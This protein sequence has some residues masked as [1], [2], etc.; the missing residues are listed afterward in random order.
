MGQDPTTKIHSLGNW[1][2][3][4]R[5]TIRNHFV[6]M[7]GEFLGTFLFL[8]FSFAPTQ[9]AVTALKNGPSTSP[10]IPDTSALLF[11]AAAFGV[12]VT[13]NVWAF[14]R[15]NGGMLNPAVTLGL[16]LIGA[17]PLIRG[18]LVFPCQI[19][20]GISAAGVV[21]ALFPG[22]LLVNVSLGAGTSIVQ[23]LFIEMFLTIQFLVVIFMLAVEKHRAT[24]LAP[25][26]IGMTLFICHMTAVYYTGCGV[27]PARAFG[28]D[29]VNGGFPSYHWIYWLGPFM[30]AFVAAGIY[31]LFKILGYETANPGQDGGK[32]IV[33][34][35]YSDEESALAASGGV[36]LRC[37]Q[38]MFIDE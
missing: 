2:T 13:V 4:S 14:Y 28:P 5:N 24:F 37:F 32:E 11:I 21:S 16:V 29:V 17:V 9:I 12:S 19:L 33:G 22:P 27:N 34:L 35:L 7:I 36:E 20:A 6:A 25:I 1:T 15:I 38:G 8:F 30:G 31:K 26:G 10:P 23:G 18:L 3:G